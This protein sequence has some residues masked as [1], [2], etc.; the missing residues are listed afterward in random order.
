MKVKRYINTPKSIVT[1]FLLQL[2]PKDH[3]ETTARRRVAALKPTRTPAILLMASV[4]VRVGG[5]VARVTPIST[6]VT[7]LP[8]TTV[9]E[10]R[11]VRIQTA[12]SSVSVMSASPKLLM[13]LVRV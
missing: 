1:H 13:K 8:Y 3:G 6:S 10:T 7:T 2:A 4:P 9:P 12:H 11:R 5:V